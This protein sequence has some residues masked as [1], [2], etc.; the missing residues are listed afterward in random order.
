[1]SK[2]SLLH[3]YFF[4]VN[5]ISNHKTN[6]ESKEE[7]VTD[8][9]MRSCIAMIEYETSWRVELGFKLRVVVVF[10]GIKK[11]DTKEDPDKVFVKIEAGI[12]EFNIAT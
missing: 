2:I 12:G 5:T 7:K 1:M 9:N 8:G 11:D 4:P 10:L 3:F 6:E